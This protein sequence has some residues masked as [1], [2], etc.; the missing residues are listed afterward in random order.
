MTSCDVKYG[1][2]LSKAAVL[3]RNLSEYKSMEEEL[4]RAKEKAEESTKAKS[5]FLANMSHELRTPM[6]GIIGMCELLLGSGLNAEQ[7]DLVKT[8][9]A[10]SDNL[11]QLLNDILDISKLESGD[12]MLEDVPFDIRIL[13]NEVAKL[14]AKNAAEKG[15]ELSVNVRDDIP[16]VMLGDPARL[17]QILRNLVTNA[18]KFTEKGE[19][20]INVAMAEQMG[21]NELY[22]QVKD[23]GIG[24]PED[25]LDI[26]FEKF[27]QADTS[28][29][30]KYGGTGLGLAITK[31]LIS[32]MNGR[33]GVESTVGYGSIFYFTIP[34]RVAPEHAMPVNIHTETVT[35][36]MKDFSKDI[37][38][39]AV[40][41]HPINIMFIEK[42]LKKIGIKHIDIAE[43]GL[44][45]LYMIKANKYDLVFMDCQM[46]EFDGYEATRIL[47]AEGQYDNL[48]IVAMTAN[49][50]VGDKE[51]C[52][53]AGMDDYISKPIKM[54]SVTEIIK[55]WT[56]TNPEMIADIMEQN[57]KA[58]AATHDGEPINMEHLNMFTDGDLGEERMLFEMFL[59]SA[60]ESIQVLKTSK[61]DNEAWRK[62]AHKLKGAAANLGAQS[63]AEVMKEAEIGFELDA[64]FKKLICGRITDEMHCITMFISS[65]QS[66]E[67]LS[68]QF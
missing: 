13:V 2:L 63:L 30:R 15:L 33:L 14:Y 8:L 45:A 48:P 68:V 37:R 20:K 44:E 34:S 50:M 39:L 61:N 42:L 41:D 52:L 23:T 38:V 67:D 66:S 53:K 24:V 35:D 32:M 46:P 5:E 16:A 3:E 43:N 4:I 29:T 10:S 6:N 36:E 7:A 21:K 65:R 9:S 58:A 47:R 26:I 25:K 51:K 59:Q 1:K 27:Q 57:V 18:L 56:K 19:I 49:A 64:A 40:D 54:E 28:I 17:Q 22:F 55:K 11:L 31:E 60:T 62:A 12:L